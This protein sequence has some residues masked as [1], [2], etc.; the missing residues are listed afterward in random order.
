[1]DEKLLNEAQK[2][3]TNVLDISEIIAEFES[4]KLFEN[5][6]LIKPAK[7]IFGFAPSWISH[8][9]EFHIDT[10][11][12]VWLNTIRWHYPHT[13]M[14]FIAT[15]EYKREE[16]PTFRMTDFKR[17]GPYKANKILNILYGLSNGLYDPEPELRMAASISLDNVK[18]NIRI[19]ESF[20]IKKNE[21]LKIVDDI[22]DRQ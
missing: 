16:N 17:I 2:E 3:S 8:Y 19:A 12:G 1:M 4:L 7:S 15:Y 18:K 9:N 21:I 10:V 11:K 6:D 22:Y 20:G 14:C 13:L 5:A